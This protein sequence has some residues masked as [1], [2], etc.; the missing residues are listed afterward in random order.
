MWIAYYV[1]AFCS[2]SYDEYLPCS[3]DVELFIYLYSEFCKYGT[4]WIVCEN[5]LLKR[6]KTY[7]D[8][9]EVVI[10]EVALVHLWICQPF[11]FNTFACDFASKVK[12]HQDSNLS[13]YISRK[14]ASTRWKLAEFDFRPRA[15]SANENST[16]PPGVSKRKRFSQPIYINQLS[17]LS[18]WSDQLG[19]ASDQSFIPCSADERARLCPRAG[20]EV[21]KGT[22]SVQPGCAWAKSWAPKFSR[23]NPQSGIYILVSQSLK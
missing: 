21:A 11:V 19:S 22:S 10:M 17:I 4:H 20:N 5:S 3:F 23:A 6:K 16:F 12:L 9:W 14:S 8:S 7:D 15:I 18:K 1:M 2:S 13:L